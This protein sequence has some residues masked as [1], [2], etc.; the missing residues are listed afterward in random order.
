MVTFLNLHFLAKKSSSELRIYFFFPLFKVNSILGFNDYKCR[1]EFHVVSLKP[2]HSFLKPSLVSKTNSLFFF[3][4]TMVSLKLFW[5][6]NGILGRKW[7]KMRFHDLRGIKLWNLIFFKKQPK[8]S[9]FDDKK[10]RQKSETENETVNWFHETEN[11]FTFVKKK[12]IFFFLKN[13]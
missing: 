12:Y 5:F 10:Y 2:Q 9:C 4:F 8:N 13:F 11:S 7:L 1:I 3:G 6:Q